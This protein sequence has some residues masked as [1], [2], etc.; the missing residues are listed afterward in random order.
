MDIDQWLENIRRAIGKL[1]IKDDKVF[2]ELWNNKLLRYGGEDPDLFEIDALSTALACTCLNRQKPFLVVLP[3]RNPARPALLFATGLILDA[4]SSGKGQKAQIVLYAGS[5]IGIRDQLANVYARKL[6]LD[7]VFVQSHASS[8]NTKVQSADDI[9][10]SLP[11]VATV[12]APADPRTFLDEYRPDWI[13][14]DCGDSNNLKWLDAL[15]SNA[16]ERNIPIVGWCQN[17]LSETVQA[18]SAHG[19]YIFRWPSVQ[20]LLSVQKKIDPPNA[21]VSAICLQGPDIVSVENHL[22]QAYQVLRTI[23]RRNP[24]SRMEQD[25]LSM[26]WKQLRLLERLS[27][28]LS[29]YE[30]E[31]ESYWGLRTVRHGQETLGAFAQAL[32]GAT[33]LSSALTQFTRKLEQAITEIDHQGPPHWNALTE[34]CITDVESDSVRLLLFP[35]DVQ[36]QLFELGLLAY[37]NMSINDLATLNVTLLSARDF[38][39][40]GRRPW[41]GH[42]DREDLPDLLRNAP[43]EAWQLVIPGLPN[44]RLLAQL[45]PGLQAGV[46]LQFLLYSHQMPSLSWRLKQCI[47]ALSVRAEDVIHTLSGLGIPT[48][49]LS[50]SN[51]PAPLRKMENSTIRLENKKKRVYSQVRSLPPAVLNPVEEM[52][53]LFEDDTELDQDKDGVTLFLDHNE[54]SSDEDSLLVDH[55]VEVI[56]Q[57]GWYGLF[58]PD[59]KLNVIMQG[60]S[61]SLQLRYVSSLRSG[62]QVLFI[63]GQRR[64]NLY[65]LVIQRVHNHP[66]FALHVE[67]VKRW[68]KDVAI[69]Y[70][71]WCQ[72]GDRSRN[73]TDLLAVLQARGSS[74]AVSLTVEGWVQGLRLC[75][76]DK[77]DLRRLAE[78]LNMDFVIQNY[79]LIFKAAERLRGKHRSWGRQLNHWLLQDT[80]SRAEV[81]LFDEELGLSFGDLK[82]SLLPLHIL[83]LQ[84]VQGPFYRGNLG[85]IKKQ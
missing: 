31:A 81:E 36:Y 23:V 77:E 20:Q 74:I 33:G 25:V 40:T 76:K 55:A 37:C 15:L 42:P 27:V 16:V 41:I 63:H 29:F 65:E 14:V 62:N 61:S 8:R 38:Y 85:E 52:A 12:Y 66:A 17:P 9:A 46:Q 39:G 83:T 6:R 84:S 51:V 59:A 56:F 43:P 3:D 10:N 5:H 80:S 71:R 48:D 30:S 28:P 19:A 7:E 34:L 50:V 82:G 44:P 32:Q 22:Q 64:Q 49:S 54:D 26:S 69:A 58:A 53:R 1:P 35:S 68:Q 47:E 72:S 13:A 45:E 79:Q 67:L 11:R 18:F 57:E 24:K 60:P 73:I 4:I 70:R 75:P 21:L 78:V 2:Q